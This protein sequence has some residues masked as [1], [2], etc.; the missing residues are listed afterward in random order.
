MT[1]LLTTNIRDKVNS[2]LQT[3]GKAKEEA[4]TDFK[5]RIAHYVSSYEPLTDG[6]TPWIKIIDAGRKVVLHR[7]SEYILDRLLT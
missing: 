7:I 5:A 3:M 4:L 1:P 6:I 2:P